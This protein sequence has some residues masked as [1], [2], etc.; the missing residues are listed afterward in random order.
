MNTVYIYMYNQ[1]N[2]RTQLATARYRNSACRDRT[3][4]TTAPRTNTCS[5]I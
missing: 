2:N 4:N 1:R 5:K 3:R